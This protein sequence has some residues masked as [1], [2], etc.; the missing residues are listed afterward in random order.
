MKPAIILITASLFAAGVA[1]AATV[2]E[3]LA[4]YQ[5][6]GAKNFS[7]QTGEALWNKE[8]AEAATGP[9]VARGPRLGPVA[10]SRSGKPRSCATC[11]GRNL[12]EAGKHA[13]T[14]KAI[15]PMRPAVNAK[16]LTDAKQI[17]KWFLRNCKWTYGRECTPQEKGDFLM[18]IKQ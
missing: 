9:S 2:D 11:H 14:G 5:R 1:Q 7:A 18:F 8:F 16:R 13:E 6:Q 17:E 4:D 3:R 10:D 12:G 15:E